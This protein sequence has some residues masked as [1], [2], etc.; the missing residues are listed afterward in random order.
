MK[1]WFKQSESLD[2]FLFVMN[3][4]DPHLRV[5]IKLQP[6]EPFQFLFNKMA[7]EWMKDGLI[8]NVVIASYEREVERYGGVHL[9]EAAEEL[10]CANSQSVAHCL[11]A[12]GNKA[13]EFDEIIFHTMSVLCFLQNFHLDQKEAMI[14]LDPGKDHLNA[15]KDYRTYKKQLITLTQEL[16]SSRPSHQGITLLKEALNICKDAQ[17]QFYNK[18]A[19]HISSDALFSIYDSLLHM[20]CNRL[21]CGSAAE[22]RGRAYAHHT[23]KH[24]QHLSLLWN[25]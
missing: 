23:L 8:K 15:L 25:A 19:D 9:I 13:F 10:F 11:R 20:H 16:E 3:D 22:L 21:G 18:S 14:L 4:P 5:R 6:E 24:L 17:E 7:Q 2:G 1:I 12:F